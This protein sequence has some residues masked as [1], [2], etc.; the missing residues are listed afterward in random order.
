MLLLAFALG[1]GAVGW[2]ERLRLLARYQRGF[3]IVRVIAMIL[4]GLYLFNVY[5]FVV[6]ELAG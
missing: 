3:E 6:P 4:T 1:N 5:F 2:L